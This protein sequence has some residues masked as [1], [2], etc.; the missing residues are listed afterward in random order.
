MGFA[1]TASVSVRCRSRRPLLY[2][3]SYPLLPTAFA[4]LS[5]K[6]SW[7]ATSLYK[8]VSPNRLSKLPHNVKF[9]TIKTSPHT[10]TLEDLYCRRELVTDT[11]AQCCVQSWE[12]THVQSSRQQVISVNPPE[13]VAELRHYMYSHKLIKTVLYCKVSAWYLISAGVYFKE[14]PLVR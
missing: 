11:H 2:L 5:Q 13:H 6:K 7:E 12:I 8:P 14:I 9:V 3:R 1:N 4:L 10:A